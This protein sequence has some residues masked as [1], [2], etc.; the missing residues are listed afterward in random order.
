VVAE[1]LQDVANGVC[2]FA[3][4][5]ENVGVV[6]VGEDLS[7]ASGCAVDGACHPDSKS[8]QAAGEALEAVSLDQ[9]VEVVALHGEV[10]HP[11]AEP[12]LTFADCGF[13]RV[14]QPRSPQIADAEQG[15]Q[16]YVDRV[17]RGKSLAA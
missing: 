13:N 7:S 17:A 2:D 9:Q 8:L 14:E 1:V 16:S 12:L 4:G 6:P 15:S 5:A 3:A 11:H 10:N